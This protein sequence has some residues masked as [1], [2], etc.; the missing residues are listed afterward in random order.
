MKKDDDQPREFLEY[1]S[2]DVDAAVSK[3]LEQIYKRGPSR[4]LSEFDLDAL[5]EEFAELAKIYEA[6]DLGDQRYAVASQLSLVQEFFVEL[7]IPRVTLTPAYRPLEALAER[8]SNRIDPMFAKPKEGHKKT[9]GRPGKSHDDHNRMGVLAGLANF[10]LKNRLPGLTIEEKLS[11][12]ARHF[13]GKW[14]GEV[15]KA[16]LKRARMIVSQETLEHAS[17]ATAEHCRVQLEA[18]AVNFGPAA[19]IEITIRVLNEAP[20][21]SALGNW[22]TSQ[23]QHG[24][25]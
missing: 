18:L 8:E 22:A 13:K 19:A 20:A 15:T 24:E 9:G 4:D 11:I 10:W 2:A 25:I 1:S 14:F 6:G 7:G 12:A 21:S 17:V 5:N 23:A 16:D 3:M